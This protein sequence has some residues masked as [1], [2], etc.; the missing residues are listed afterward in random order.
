[1]S[2]ETS[3]DWVDRVYMTRAGDK[4]WLFPKAMLVDRYVAFRS[5]LVGMDTQRLAAPGSHLTNVLD[6]Q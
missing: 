6:T 5:P 1:M 4:A 3:I 2:V